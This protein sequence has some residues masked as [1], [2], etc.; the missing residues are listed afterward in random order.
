[1]LI[2]APRKVVHSRDASGSFDEHGDGNL[3]RNECNV[4]VRIVGDKEE[5]MLP[6]DI[7]FDQAIKLVE[8]SAQANLDEALTLLAHKLKGPWQAKK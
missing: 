7:T 1:M 3:N 4:W 6:K 5:V 2:P 8:E